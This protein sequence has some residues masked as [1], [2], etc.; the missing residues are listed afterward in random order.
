MSCVH[1]CA[2][3][4]AQIRVLKT[5]YDKTGATFMV[6]SHPGTRHRHCVIPV[7]SHNSGQPDRRWRRA[8][9]SPVGRYCQSAAGVCCRLALP[10]S[11]G[12]PAPRQHLHCPQCQ[13]PHARRVPARWFDLHANILPNARTDGVQT[14]NKR[15]RPGCGLSNWPVTLC[16]P[17]IAA[18][19]MPPRASLAP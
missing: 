1:A 7:D 13:R 12:H 18:N 8:G 15:S 9:C 16:W 17:H 14:P 11:L 3:H 4:R 19:P 5:L 2:D 6:R 10:G